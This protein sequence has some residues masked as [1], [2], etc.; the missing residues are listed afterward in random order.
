MCSDNLCLSYCSVINIK[1]EDAAATVQVSAYVNPLSVAAQKI[2]PM[3]QVGGWAV[4]VL[5]WLQCSPQ[6]MFVGVL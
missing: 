3:L 4:T 2:A 5:S 1:P 6:L